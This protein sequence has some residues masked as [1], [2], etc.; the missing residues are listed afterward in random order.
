M[1]EGIDIVIP[2]YNAYD[3]LNICLDSVYK[4]TD[5]H[6]N[7][8]ILINDNSS[9]ERIKSYLDS[10]QKKHVIVIHNGENKGFS[11][12]INIGMAQSENR[13]VILLNSDTVV[14]E[15]WVEKIAK[16]A[17]SDSS[18]GT[19]TPLSNNATLC[20]VPN[21][22]EENILPE[23]MTIDQAAAIVEECS[24]KKYPRI[25]VA[26]GFCMFVKRE[27]INTI[28]N[29]D[30]DTFGRGYGEENDFCNRAEQ[31]GYIHV[32]CDDTYIYHSGTKSFVSKEKEDYIREHEQILYKRY[33]F[34][35]QKNVEHCRDNPN[36]WVGHNVDFHLD[37]NNGKRNILFLLQSN[38]DLG[39]SDNIGGVQIHVKHLV[40]GMK[41]SANI[42]V[43]A[44]NGDYLKV[45]VYIGDKEHVFKFWIGKNPSYPIIRDRELAKVFANIL[46]GFNIDLVHVH[47]TLSTSLDIF[48]ETSKRNIP[49]VFSIHDFYSICPN[50]VLT[51]I[52]GEVCIGKSNLQC[53]KCLSV[54]RDVYEGIRFLEKWRKEYSRIL[55]SCKLII[56][57]SEVAKNI[58][59][60][61]YP[62]IKEKILIIEHGI[63]NKFYFAEDLIKTEQK[64][65][66][67]WKVV[68]IKTDCKCCFMAV[69]VSS[70]INPDKVIFR[71]TDKLNKRIY[72]PS[73]FG[74]NNFVELTEKRFFG[75][76]PSDGL[77]EGKLRIDILVKRAN[78][79]YI[80]E[81]IKYTFDYS[82]VIDEK[83]IKIAFIGGINKDKGSENII[84]LIQKGHQNIEW[85]IFGGIGDQK[86]Y[87]L[88][89]NNLTKTSFYHSED[90][91]LHLKNH[92]ID[93][94]CLL[95]K[96]PETFSYTL[97]EAVR[98]GIPVIVTDLGALGER[99]IKYKYGWVVSSSN[100][101]NEVLNIIENIIA[102]RGILESQKQYLKALSTKSIDQMIEEYGKQYDLIFDQKESK[103]K[104]IAH[105]KNM[106]FIND[107]NVKSYVMNL[108]GLNNNMLSYAKMDREICE[109]RHFQTTLAY[110]IIIKFQKVNFPYKE[111]LRQKL[112]KF[113][114]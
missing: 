28:G 100:T 50:Q 55:D 15:N 58:I 97:S 69:E 41:N 23:G 102:N 75:F 27:V 6:K 45:S 64:D 38:F 56:A 61:Y 35:M 78:K 59:C 39:L 73:N 4:Y 87:N 44:R 86:L 112:I 111:K 92:T 32:M 25:T 91:G 20:S 89:K 19:V 21:F 43:V 84:E 77:A 48:N 7:R 31:M 34:Q 66:L 9:D 83:K 109:Y 2:I 113:V 46:E 76:I 90:I 14:T 47:H 72:L 49:I 65:D 18:I 12:N 85:Y 79:V 80:N 82:P 99:C 95:S 52:D 51:E 42:F 107:A 30:A 74:I 33:P 17:Y 37:I 70:D 13:D 29:F 16:C 94:I 10:Q 5:L 114:K 105:K 8:L 93:I 110:K 1:G 81:N 54:T 106:E 24:L 60:Q 71:V 96:V 22:C 11:N 26:N 62:K 88:K 53:E 104:Y 68:M 67:K 108:N 103:I 98:S 3:D 36:G 57:P 40:N 101:V 63:D